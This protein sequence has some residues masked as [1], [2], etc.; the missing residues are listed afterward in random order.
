M[1]RPLVRHI[2]TT[3]PGPGWKLDVEEAVMNEFAP[4]VSVDNIAF[5][6]NKADLAEQMQKVSSSVTIQGLGFRVW[7]LGRNPKP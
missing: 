2:R 7:G 1:T 6:M 5:H 3:M 4:G